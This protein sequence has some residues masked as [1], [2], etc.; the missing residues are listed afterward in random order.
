MSELIETKLSSEIIYEGHFL[1]VRK[2][3]VKLPNGKTANRE[4]INHP[5]AV[6]ILPILP[7]GMIGMIRQYR[8]AVQDE[9][10]EL[11]AGKLDSG[12]EPLACAARELQEEIGYKAGRLTYLAQ[13]HPAIGFVNEVMSIYLAENLE[14]TES[15]PDTDEFIQL[16]P[17]TLEDALE[18]VWNGTITDAKTIIGVFWI[19]RIIK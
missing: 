6:L 19:N 2:D 4:W 1:D 5:G 18:M 16:F 13:I 15:N 17:S 3:V 9:F 12:E 11:P 10:I 14:K 7:D 8:Y